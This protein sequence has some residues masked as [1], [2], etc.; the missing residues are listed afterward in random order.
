VNNANVLYIEQPAGVGFSYSDDPADYITNDTRA[1]EDNYA[2]LQGF[3]QVF[4]EYVGRDLWLT[5]ESYGGIY[6]PTLTAQILDGSDDQLA[7]QLTGWMIGNGVNFCPE[8]DFV[9]VQYNIY[10]WHG[11]VSPTN[12]ANWTN[13]GCNQNADT[14]A[15]NDILNIAQNQIGNIVQQLTPMDEEPSLDPDDLYQDFCTGNGTLEFAIDDPLNCS[16]VGG[17][18]ASYLNRDD[19]QTAIGA[20]PTYWVEVSILLVFAIYS[21][22]LTHLTNNSAPT[23]S[24]TLL[25]I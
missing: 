11:L 24:T 13:N 18:V 2:F 12:Y 14:P 15:C 7:S 3:L 1:A 20:K 4:P 10:Y 6:I 8:L 9:S 17:R 19:V 21:N 22:T 5:G 25:E 16:T 23:T